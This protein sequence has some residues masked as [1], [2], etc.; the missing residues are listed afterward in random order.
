MKAQAQPTGILVQLAI[1]GRI[2][3]ATVLICCVVYTLVILAIGQ[4]LTP[5]TA[6][7]SLIST[8]QGDIGSEL[9]AQGFSRPEYFWPRPSAVAYNA[10]AAG[11]SNLSPTSPVLRQRAEG[12]LAHLQ[13]KPVPTDVVTASGSGLD[14]HLTIQAAR[15]QI[16]R[17]A[18]ARGRTAEQLMQLLEQHVEHVGRYSLVNVLRVNMALDKMEP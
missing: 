16:E 7:G 9:I 2:V 8:W 1:S 5:H 11:G 15:G 3:L 18:A 6:N 4:T 13:V 12:I 17:I 10:S 14:P